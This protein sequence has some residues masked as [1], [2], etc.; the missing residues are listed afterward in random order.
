MVCLVKM[1]YTSRYL[2]T[3]SSC[4][5]EPTYRQALTKAWQ[6]VWHTKIL[7]IFGLLSA[8]VGQF[9]LPNFV[10]RVLAIDE[11]RLLHLSDWSLLASSYLWSPFLNVWSLWLL[12]VLLAV[13]VLVIL[14]SVAAEGALIAASTGAFSLLGRTPT[15]SRSWHKGVKHFWRLLGM[16]VL[17]RF[18]LA[19]NFLAVG[20]LL[21]AF[22]GNNLLGW[23]AFYVNALI[24]SAGFVVAFAVSTIAK[25]AS[26]YI[27]HDE[28]SLGTAIT[29]GRL[30]FEHHVLVS[31][32]LAI[33]ELI[34]SIALMMAFIFGGLWILTPS[35]ILTLVGAATGFT[36]L[37]A[38]GIYATLALYVLIIAIVGGIFH[39][40]ITSSW[41]Y[42]FI[43][44]H[45]EGVSSRVLHWFGFKRRK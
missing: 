6:L 29:K 41:M 36:S 31:L 40:F 20:Y 18:V 9:G 39:A 12:V 2:V 8:L 5:L 23:G 35:V 10:G 38:F 34:L 28:N 19:V 27:V 22:S 7:W 11:N 25:Y 16:K 1:C 42:M 21:V 44:M 15:T 4:M 33:I 45:H 26:G 13:L 24:F 43:K 30:L 14:V 3:I 17:E 37:I 32:E